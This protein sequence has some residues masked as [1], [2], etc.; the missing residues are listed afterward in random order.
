MITWNDIEKMVQTRVFYQE[1]EWLGYK[2]AEKDVPKDFW[3]T[4][5]AFAN[6]LGGFVIFGISEINN[7]I[8]NHLVISG[9]K[10]AQKIQDDLFSQSRSKEKVSS[11]L[12]SNNSVRQFEID[13]KTIIVIYVSPAA[14]AER[15]VHLNQDPRRSYVRLKTGDHQLQGDELRSFLSS[16]TQK[17]AD[18]QILPH[19]NLDDLSLITLNKYRQ[20]IKAETPDSPLLNLSD[21]QFVR[22]VNIYKRD[23]K[24]NIE[25]L[26]YAGLLLFGKGYVIKE[27]LPHFFFEYYEKSDE[28]ERYDFRITD[29]DL[30]QGNLFEFY[31]KV[32]P[33]ITALGKD[34]HFKL[35]SLT[36]TAEN[37]ITKA[38]REAL[39][40]AI[41]HADYFNNVRHLKIIKS[42]NQLSFENAGVMLVDIPL[43]I[44]G[45]RSECRNSLIHNILRRAGLGERQGK[46]VRDIFINWKNR[47]FNVPILESQID[48]TKLILTFQDG[49][50]ATAEENL[51]AC[52]DEF[53][54]ALSPIQKDCLIYIAINEGQTQHKQ[55][56]ED[57][58][59]YS[60]RNISL[61][62]AALKNKGMLISNGSPRKL[63]YSLVGFDKHLQAVNP[64]LLPTKFAKDVAK[65]TAKDVAN[66]VKDVA[67]DVEKLPLDNIIPNEFKQLKRKNGNEVRAY[68]LLL[69]RD[70]H[71]PI[72]IIAE[73]LNMTERAVQKH[74]YP[75]ISEGKLE[76]LF[77]N[78]PTHPQQA[79]KT[80]SN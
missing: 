33:R 46:G 6:T 69:C 45:D 74:I 73:R 62:L 24:S 34:T 59:Q 9:V 15:P 13:D 39:I 42:K 2:K 27:Y 22:E 21:E 32:A 60:S 41:A 78:N 16:Y 64:D 57:I 25:G 71:I 54:S 68:L 19:S 43:A 50:I 20:Q 48:H 3:H 35:D 51:I 75:L 11:T 31:L 76:P 28:N 14:A 30:E 70:N 29:F 18:S 8:E 79:Y 80:K 72:K 77:S 47:Y 4:Y 38:L 56:A 55:L 44:A 52:F 26:T 61:A 65:D 49:K 63:V 17:D 53:F 58:P 10:Q 36:R 1:K 23:L 12:L 40:N 37:E 7:G 67:K 66:T 5:S